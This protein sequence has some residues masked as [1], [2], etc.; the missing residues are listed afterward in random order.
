[1]KRTQKRVLG[2]FGLT[3][4]VAATFVAAMLPGPEASATNTVTDR[5]VVRVISDNPNV[6]IE[7][8]ENGSAFVNPIQSIPFTYE[9]VDRVVVTLEYT[10][11]EGVTHFYTIKT[12]DGIDYEAGSDTI[13]LNLSDPGFGYG[14]YVFRVSGEVDGSVLDQDSV[15]FSF[16]P[17][18]AT[19]SEDPDNGL[20]YADLEYDDTNDEIDRFEIN[21]FDKYGNPVKGFPTITAT[22]PTKR[23]ELPFSKYDLPFGEYVVSVTTFGKSGQVLYKSYDTIANYE[24]VKTPDTGNAFKN[25]NISQSDYLITGLV[26]F[27]LVGISGLW[28]VKT[29]KR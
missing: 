23:V 8:I 19:V 10:D 28:F 6:E 16:Y 24:A 27:F 3:L 13:D 20:I 9:S 2:F 1:M 15:A 21:I 11:A 26:V 25:L 5:L 18:I 29:H 22:P 17:V 14:Q 12:I 7:K 4:V